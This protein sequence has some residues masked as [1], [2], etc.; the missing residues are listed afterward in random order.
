MENMSATEIPICVQHIH[1]ESRRVVLL[2]ATSWPFN[3]LKTSAQ[4]KLS[5]GNKGLGNLLDYDK[6]ETDQTQTVLPEVVE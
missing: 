2:P 4:T 3:W 6:E 5:F 1:L